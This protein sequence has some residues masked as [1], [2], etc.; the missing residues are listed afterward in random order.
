MRVRVHRNLHLGKGEVHVWTIVDPRSERVIAHVDHV[1]IEGA[2]CRVQEGTRQRVCR[3]RRRKVHAYV[4]GELR[5]TSDARL[6]RKFHVG[7]GNP[8][9]EGSWTR[10]TYNPFRAPTFTV[11]D[12]DNPLPVFGAPRMRFDVQGAWRMEA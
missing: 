12:P 11:A 1:E 6:R 7:L 8:A 4:V 9:R 10:V 2:E 5:A 3:K